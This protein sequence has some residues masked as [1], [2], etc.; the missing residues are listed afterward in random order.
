MY[1]TTY[2]G[3]D[4]VKSEKFE[5]QKQPQTGEKKARGNGATVTTLYGYL[6]T[7]RGD[8]KGKTVKNNKTTYKYTTD[9]LN[10]YVTTVEKNKKKTTVVSNTIKYDELNRIA[11]LDGTVYSY[12]TLGRLVRAEDQKNKRSWEYTYD[13]L[14]NITSCIY[15]DNGTVGEEKYSYDR[16]NLVRFD[17]VKVS[18]YKGG[19]PKNYLG[20]TLK[21]ERGRQLKSVTPK[22]GK[23]AVTA[24]AE[25]TYAGDGS[26]LSKTVGRTKKNKGIRTD[27]ILNGSLI[28]AERHA[29]NGA[30]VPEETLNY[31]YSSEGRLLEIGYCTGSGKERHYSVIRNA[32][33]DVVALYTAE[34]TLV[35]TYEYDPYGKLLSVIPNEAYNDTDNILIKNPFRY[36]G[37]YYDNETGWYYLQSR[38]YDPTVRRFINADTPDLLTN[39][40]DNLMQ[41]NLFMYCNGDPVNGIDPSGHD[42]SEALWYLA[43]SLLIIAVV[44]TI[45]PTGGGSAGAL[46]F[47]GGG[48][49]GGGAIT[50]LTSSAAVNSYLTGSAMAA[51]A[52]AY[53]SK[54]NNRS[55]SNHHLSGKEMNNYKKSIMEGDDVTFSSK[56][57]AE[58]FIK[59]KFPDLKQ[60]I[61]GQ[62]SP[63]G[64]HY[65]QHVIN[66]RGGQPIEHIKLYSKMHGFRVHIFW[67]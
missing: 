3:F 27:Y 21:W 54:S 13:A 66:G 8:P 25:Y 10:K 63:N 38:Y 57:E 7:D 33:G 19:N 39:D 11:D 47:V 20:N 2:D 31:Y 41:Y 48:T 34:G 32:L 15:T 23:Y 26:R 28:L 17:G 4:R 16:Q 35:G 12:D 55:G 53:L 42:A 59:E 52:S 49:V 67:E 9:L 46:V 64:L 43:I 29:G 14:G 45:I 51:G 6:D 22:K 65:D 18:G 5:P 61:P 56:N 58:Q 62:R 40:C 1:K 24:K 37:Y 36:R 30:D 60:D 50:T 44:A